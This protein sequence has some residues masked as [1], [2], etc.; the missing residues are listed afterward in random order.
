VARYLTKQIPG[1]PRVIVKN[2]PGASGVLL[3]NH[4]YHREKPTGLA[5]GFPGRSYPL[6]PLLGDPGAKFVSTKFSFIGTVSQPIQVLFLRSALG[7]KNL[8][9][10]KRTKKQ[11]YMP[12]LSNRASNVMVPRVLK[13]YM[14]WP[15]NA[16]PG[17]TA[18]AKMH[19]A[20]DSGEGDGIFSAIESIKGTR[21]DLVVSLVPIVQTGPYFPG[22]P[23]LRDEITKD[24]KALL[25]LIRA[26]A[27]WGVPL[28]G[29]PGI[30]ENQLAVLRKAFVRM[31]EQEEFKRDAKRQG[32]QVKPLN[33]EELEKVVKQVVTNA[34]DKVVSEY[35]SIMAG[36]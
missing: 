1:S 12:G 26:P 35:K 9:G 10:L 17:Y 7:I 33:G 24:V 13:K 16:V 23:L 34:S 11:I 14:G 4:L 2:M 30:P 22:V 19:L 31:T 32:L 36:K 8:D 3:A 28:I 20:L 15:L 27:L 25:D 18:T 6:A 21:P 29:P 5:I